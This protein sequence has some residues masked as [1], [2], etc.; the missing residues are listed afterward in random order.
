LPLVGRKGKSGVLNQFTNALC[1]VNLIN[2]TFE[3]HLIK[4]ATA[5]SIILADKKDRAHHSKTQKAIRRN[6][7]TVIQDIP[8]KRLVSHSYIHNRFSTRLTIP[9]SSFIST[10]SRNPPLVFGRLCVVGLLCK[11]KKKRK[12]KAG[13]SLHI[14]PRGD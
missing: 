7:K 5:I 14:K 8:C 6:S 13:K 3:L 10:R 4:R 9:K 2:P 1:S 11:S 12:K